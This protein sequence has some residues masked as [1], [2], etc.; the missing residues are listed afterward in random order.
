MKSKI[1]KMTAALALLALF[2]LPLTG[3]G[4]TR[5]DATLNIQNYAQANNWS[6]GTKYET[7]TV[8]PVTFSASSGNNTGKYYTSG[9]E[10]RFYQTES[11]SITISVTSDYSLSSITFT[12]NST[13]SGVLKNGTN[14]VSS[15]ST[16][17][18]SGTSATFTVG[19]SGSATNGQVKFTNIVVTYV[20]AGGNPIVATPT[21]TPDGGSFLNSQ[22]VT[23]TCATDGAAIYYTLDG[24]TPSTSS[25]PY[26]EP[27]TINATT[28][29]K[30]YA[31][32]AD[33]DD[34]EV[35]TAVFTKETP[36]TVAEARDFIDQLNGATSDN[37]Y[38]TGIISQI[39]QYNSN[40]HSI[41]YWISDDG[42][43]TDQLEV[44]SGK[45]LNGADFNALTDLTLQSEVIVIGKLK[46]YNSTYE[47]TQNSQIVSLTLPVIA[48]ATPTFSPVGGT[49][50][51]VQTVTISC[52]TPNVT[53]YYTTDGTDPNNQ[54]TLYEGS[55]TVGESMTIKAIAYDNDNNTS[56]IAT[57]SYTI[58]LPL[59]EQTFSQIDGHHPVAGETYLIVDLTT[60][61]A[62]TSAN[63]SSSAPVLVATTIENNQITTNNA[64]LQWTFE[65]TDGGYIIHPLGDTTKWLYT[66]DS[67]N[68]VRVGTNENKV[69]TLNVTDATNTDYLG[70]KNNATSRYLGVYNSQDWRTYTTV[71]NNIKD[72]HIA[73]FVLGDAPAPA[74]SITANNVSIEYNATTGSIAYTVNNEPEPA[75]TMT[76]AIVEGGTIANFSLGTIANGTVPFTCDANMSGASR[77]ATVT[78]TYTYNTETV[79]KDVTITQAANPN[80]IMTIAEVRALSTGTTVTTKGI[81]TSC[82]GTT[83]YIQDATAAICVYGNSLTVGDEI[84]VTGPL[85]NYNGLLEIG[86]SGTAATV[87]EV[88][89]E[90]NTVNPELMTIAE[91]NASTNQGWYV[92][93]EEATV[94]AI[95]NKNVTIAQGENNVA[96]RFAN[97]NDITFEVSDIISLNGNIGAYNGVQIAN[98]QNVE[99]QQNTEPTITIANATVNVPA[100]GGTGTIEVTYSNFD[101]IESE[102]QFF[103]ADGETSATYDWITVEFDADNNAVYT[104]EANDGEART[105]YFKV[106]EANGYYSNLVTVTQAQYVID[107]AELPFTWAGGTKEE[108]TALNGVTG[109]GLGSNYA[110]SNAPYRV[111]FDTDGDYILIKTDQQPGVVSV[112]IKK[113]GGAGNT[114]I[115]IEGS[116]DGETFTTI[117]TFAN[118]GEAN[119]VLSHE[120]SVAFGA[121]DRYVRI[122]FNKPDGGSNVGVGP[123]SIAVVS[124]EPSITVTP[125]IIDATADETEGYLTL[126]YENIPDFDSF[127]YY[128]CDAE[129]NELEDTDPN[130]PDWIEA[131]INVPTPTEE[132]H[133]IYFIIGANDG[134]ARTAYFKVFTLIENGNDYEEVYAIVTVNQDAYVVDYAELPF[135]WAGGE[136]I[137]FE[138]LN[139]TSTYSV[140]TYGDNQGIYRMKLDND[141]DYI[142]VKCDQQP[143][144][145]TIGVKMIGGSGT[146]TITVQGSADGTTFTNVEALTISGSQNDTVNLE[147]ANA[148]AATDRYVRLL[149]TKGSNVG[150]G[151]ISIGLP[152]NAPVI[153]VSPA[154]VNLN[155]DEHDGTLDLTYANLE[156]SD[157][158]DFDI[159][160]YDAEGEETEIPEW[161]E[162][163]VAEQDPSI[164][165]GYV[166]SYFMFENEGEEARTAYFKVFALGDEDYVYSNLVTITQAAFVAP[167]LTGTIHFGSAEGSTNISSASVTGYDSK[168]NTWTI[169]TEGTTSF[170]PNA[171]YAQVGSSSKP[172]TSITFTTTFDE[173]V[174][175]AD[176]QAK[177]GG[178]SNTA[179]NISLKV[180]TVTVGTGSLNATDDVIVVN[181]SIGTGNTLTVTV[182]NIAKGVKCYYISYTILSYDIYGPTEIT[183]FTIPA[184]QTL[185][186]HDGGVLTITNTL[187]NEGTAA[188]LIIEEGGQLVTSN[189]VAATM[190]KVIAGY[191]PSTKSEG[192]WYF[193]SSPLAAEA[194]STTS[195]TN[196]IT[197]DGNY[198]LYRFE[199][200]SDGT[201]WQNFKAHDFNTFSAGEGYLYAHKEGLPIEF[202]G[203]VRASMNSQGMD[204]FEKELAYSTEETPYR[205]W[206]LVGNPFPTNAEVSLPY[207][208]LN[209]D[210]DS[211]NAI[212]N[213]AGGVIAP[214][215]GVF[216]QASAAN[217]TVIFTA[218]TEPVTPLDASSAKGA[219]TINLE[220]EGKLL[221]RAIVAI[222]RNETLGKLNLPETSTRIYIQ[223][224]NKD[225]AVVG[226][227]AQGEMPISFQT[228]ED[229]SY[230]ITVDAKNLSVN[231]LHLIDNMTGAN[232]DLLQ[233]PSYN[234]EA[235]ADDFASRFRLLFNTNNVNDK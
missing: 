183:N 7:A 118:E 140:G 73:L 153:T 187:T 234:F 205:G 222:N 88:I 108:L 164:G 41:T 209:S 39:D 127:D 19:N 71:H 122:Y 229:G 139:G 157:M 168:G 194:T 136:I 219:V 121:N 154:S 70:F 46:L 57:A 56:N 178:F 170:T 18:V 115:T 20:A 40:Y 103:A 2:I 125:A 224:G 117:D 218:T 102:A 113:L 206:N 33:Y 208:K 186:I 147:T 100:A 146:S 8:S 148:F 62:L 31:V 160:Y 94:T 191:D 126:T 159:L 169:T 214:L 123:I 82:V 60:N 228:T 207:Y 114:S 129:G 28:T 215:E 233:T 84:K 132:N 77:T 38:V 99:V 83:G 197:S 172:A 155:S 161:I 213:Y 226:A 67:N 15:G 220:H 87:D 89:S 167:T 180:D 96:V 232:I 92:R 78:L 110:E 199:E 134:E 90:N 143:G 193:I 176:F 55:I 188:N 36:M 35:A 128:F 171:G 81:V 196:L 204:A 190:Q 68:G 80:Y 112:G 17:S 1:T 95:D 174:T 173:S 179:G 189:T 27:F 144:Q 133:T 135:S 49:Y 107:Y 98:P 181:S 29:V 184:D 104:V 6:N 11:A 58:N 21:F 221:D 72:T 34:S 69:W 203:Q 177:F 24:S 54:S 63:G 3:W 10:W 65:T 51:E 130:Y 44:Y 48:V 223:Q 106:F 61:A 225:Y 182:T 85:T 105:A 22:E 141:G 138:A 227:E 42:T 47:F 59:P 5:S 165:E 64:E 86:T 175:I 53:I 13:N 231:Y 158:T 101:E 151:P 14:T 111:K 23:I 91:I 131:E 202:T 200:S 235:K 211:L 142:Q 4:Q 76:A 25:T 30:A 150:V 32:L 166:V 230:T 109:S 26:S 50:T 79:S 149:F 137:A 217:D 16:V 152:S 12:Y 162:V 74:P 192:G 201:E 9:Y 75:G 210:S 116:S 119:A 124:N 212:P 198:D 37:V 145:V 52:E 195:N 185:T 66:T 216:V 45:G 163:L 156:I 97:A 120:T 93:I 43:T